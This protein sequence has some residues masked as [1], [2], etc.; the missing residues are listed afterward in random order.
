MLSFCF[1]FGLLGKKKKKLSTTTA[2][3]GADLRVR[4][5]P[6][7]K[8]SSIGNDSCGEGREKRREETIH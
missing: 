5:E 4:E 6:H 7:L 8:N 1:F 3:A 2:A